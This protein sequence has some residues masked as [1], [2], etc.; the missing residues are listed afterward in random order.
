MN[1]TDLVKKVRDLDEEFNQAFSQ[2][3]EVLDAHQ[4]VNNQLTQY[5][6]EQED[7]L[8]NLKEEFMLQVHTLRQDAVKLNNE[9]RQEL[10]TLRNDWAKTFL[11]N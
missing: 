2:N 6:R 10:N 8:R 3:R 5:V 11:F 9:Y 1:K 4:K 7:H